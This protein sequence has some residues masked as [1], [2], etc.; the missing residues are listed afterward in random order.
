[1]FLFHVTP[2]GEGLHRARITRYDDKPP[3]LGEWKYQE[4]GRV[5]GI[6]RNALVRGVHMG[7]TI[8]DELAES[9]RQKMETEGA[10]KTLAGMIQSLR[11]AEKIAEKGDDQ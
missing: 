1:M 7:S 3:T 5:V 4:S 10:E 2:D 9:I 11:L 8:P 6:F